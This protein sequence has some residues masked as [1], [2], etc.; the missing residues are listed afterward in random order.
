MRTGARWAL[1]VGGAV[2]LAGAILAGMGG[3]VA[4]PAAAT[5]TSTGLSHREALAGLL[6]LGVLALA[7]FGF[8][9]RDWF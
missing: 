3:A 1:I 5:A 7:L 8:D 4:M 9:L 2:V 6:T